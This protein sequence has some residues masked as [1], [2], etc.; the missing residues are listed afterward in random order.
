MPRRILAVSALLVVLVACRDGPTELA[1]PVEARMALQTDVTV[2]GDAVGTAVDVLAVRTVV[3]VLDDPFVRELMDGV[4]AHTESLHRA[5]RDASIYETEAYVLTLS[6]VLTATRSRLLASAEDEGADE[7]ILRA[8]LVLV[9]DD[10]ASLL[11]QS[12]PGAER[13][14]GCGTRCNIRMRSLER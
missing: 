6:R 14:N 3:D 4:G 10:A 1:A 5:V 13:E 2:S 7:E 12:L 9:L 8:A 11:E